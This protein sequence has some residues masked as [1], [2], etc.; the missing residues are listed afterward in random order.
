MGA[1]ATQFD[2]TEFPVGR[3]LDEFSWI[4]TSEL[5]RKDKSVGKFYIRKK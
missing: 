2:Y 5:R 3:G 1:L 4:L